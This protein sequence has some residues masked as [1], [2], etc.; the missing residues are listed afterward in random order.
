MTKVGTAPADATPWAA[1]VS[2]LEEIAA[3]V[4]EPRRPLVLQRQVVI[5]ANPELR[6]RELIKCATLAAAIAGVL[7]DRGVADTAAELAGQVGIAVL[8]TAFGRWTRQDG[9][10]EL[11]RFIRETA[12]EMHT[13]T[14][15]AS[16]AGRP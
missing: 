10:R 16:P 14:A 3:E 11:S 5:D 1:V 9:G 12:D 2:A 13:L 8:H 6:E 4:F 7:R 15:R